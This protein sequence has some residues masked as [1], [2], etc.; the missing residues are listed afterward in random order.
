MCT[1]VP[2]ANRWLAH[3]ALACLRMKGVKVRAVHPCY[4]THVGKWH[5]T[6]K[7]ARWEEVLRR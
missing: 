1:K 3:R 5:V 6:S 4:E 2:Y 7:K